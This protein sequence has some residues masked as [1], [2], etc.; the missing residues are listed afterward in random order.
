MLYQVS[1]ILEKIGGHGEV[2][3][4]R[5]GCDRPYQLH[6]TQGVFIQTDK[7]PSLDFKAFPPRGERFGEGLMVLHYTKNQ[8]LWIFLSLYETTL[9]SQFGRGVPELGYLEGILYVL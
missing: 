9:L 4:L 8:D 2:L 1:I 6:H 3:G 7:K 5:E